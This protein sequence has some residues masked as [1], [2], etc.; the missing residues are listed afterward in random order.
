[1]VCEFVLTAVHCSLVNWEFMNMECGTMMQFLSR[2]KP[3]VLVAIAAVGI[4]VALVVGI[5]LYFVVMI[6]F[7][8][9]TNEEVIAATSA[10]FRS[11]F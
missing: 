6:F 3:I 1:M 11:L 8:L 2:Q 4:P 9:I 5:T 7:S 10:Y